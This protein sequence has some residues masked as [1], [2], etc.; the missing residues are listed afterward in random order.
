M[1]NEFITGEISGAFP[2]QNMNKKW[3]LLHFFMNRIKVTGEITRNFQ[4]KNGCEFKKRSVKVGIL[5]RYMPGFECFAIKM[6]LPVYGGERPL[7]YIKPI[8]TILNISNR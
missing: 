2:D 3:F 8:R 6:H 7:F 5:A 4:A 1:V